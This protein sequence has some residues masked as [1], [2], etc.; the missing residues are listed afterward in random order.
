MGGGLMELVAYGAQDIYLTG[1]PQITFFK[2]VYRRHTNFSMECIEQTFSGTRNFGGK[3]T[4]TISRNGDLV[5]GLYVTFN[6]SRVTG[7]VDN[8]KT[9]DL[10][11]NIG[12]GLIKEVDIEI[13]GQRIDRQFGK[14]MNVWN[15][16]TYSNPGG[17]RGGLDIDGTFLDEVSISAGGLADEDIY[18]NSRSTQK[19]ITEFNMGPCSLSASESVKATFASVPLDFFGSVATLV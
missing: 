9:N 12:Y 10:Y 19:Q 14:W 7:T 2:V 3:V 16:L 1:N 13:G 15:D 18:G 4:A 8:S 11:A 6:P 17:N 5:S